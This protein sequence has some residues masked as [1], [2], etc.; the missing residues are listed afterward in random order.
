MLN[1]KGKTTEEGIYFGDNNT[2][3]RCIKKCVVKDFKVNEEPKLSISQSIGDFINSLCMCTDQEAA[4][5]KES[6]ESS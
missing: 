3:N 1:N 2:W 5:K 4:F 6:K